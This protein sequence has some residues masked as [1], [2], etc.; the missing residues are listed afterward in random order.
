MEFG[1]VTRVT[2]QKNKDG[3]NLV[4]MLQCVLSDPLDVQSIEWLSQPGDDSPPAIASAVAI[5][6]ISESYKVAVS[7]DDRVLPTM[8]PGEKH[9]YSFNGIAVKAFIKFLNSGVLE[10]NGDTDFAV[11]FSVLETAFN[12]LK[13]SYNA[14]THVYAPGPGSPVPTAAPLPQSTADMSGAKINEIK[15]P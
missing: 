2:I 6:Q 7:V 14:H 1:I 9:L 8:S 13:A 4:R 5:I 12:Q 3:K 11:R 10:L 15:V